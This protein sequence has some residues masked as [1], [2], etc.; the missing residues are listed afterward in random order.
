MIPLARV[1][2][3]GVSSGAH[4]VRREGDRLARQLIFAFWRTYPRN[5]SGTHEGKSNAKI[6]D[7]QQ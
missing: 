3:G 4:P 1:P 5:N 7:E 2:A 6:R